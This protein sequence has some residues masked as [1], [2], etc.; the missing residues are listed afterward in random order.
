V[1]RWKI[2]AA[3]L[4][5]LVWAS[6]VGVVI[7]WTPLLFFYRLATRRSDPDRYR[8][9][10]FFHDSAVVAGALN[11]FWR[12]R[13]LDEVHPDPR[14]PYVFVANHRSN[15]DAFLIVRLPWEMKWLAKNAVMK[16]PLLGWQMRTA[17]DVPVAR[18]QKESRQR[19]MEEM[20][21]WLDRKVSVFLFPEGT[22]SEDGSLGAFREGAF[23]LAI[24]AG[25][26]VV[27]LAIEGT[28][29]CLPKHSLIFQPATAT[30]TVLPPVS[31]AGLQAADSA[32]LAA[33][34]RERI[35][36]HLDGDPIA[37]S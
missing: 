32:R 26:D 15:A 35:R 12:F 20:R 1:L 24:E 18:G 34:V 8:V 37:P 6:F 22:R 11:P 19:A 3:P 36:R 33:G 29:E 31:T 21:K 23:R 10:R 28:E 17:G 27:P 25:V 14:R 16:I 5:F 13:I 9:G 30:I 2:L 7:A 4:S